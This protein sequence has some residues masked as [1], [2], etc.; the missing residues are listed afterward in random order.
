MPRWFTTSGAKSSPR[1]LSR[2]SVGF[3]AAELFPDGGPSQ[4]RPAS[5]VSL[6]MI[7]AEPVPLCLRGA[8]GHRQRRSGLDG[9]CRRMGIPPSPPSRRSEEMRLSFLL[10][11]AEQTRSGRPAFVSWRWCENHDLGAKQDRDCDSEWSESGALKPHAIRSKSWRRSCGPI[12]LRRRKSSG[13]LW[14][15]GRLSRI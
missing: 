6:D 2:A 8:G 7:P 4:N 11:S 10:E 12:A 15:C 5:K 3:A 13:F 1:T 9:D 14:R